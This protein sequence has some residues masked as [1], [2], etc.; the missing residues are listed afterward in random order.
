MSAPSTAVAE[1]HAVDQRLRSSP[2]LIAY[3]IG[4]IVLGVVGLM[5]RD[6]ATNWQRVGPQVPLRTFLACAAALCELVFGAALLWRRTARVAA[7]LLT[8]F[9]A[10]FVLLWVPPILAHPGVYDGYGN[11]FEELSLVI[12]GAVAVAWLAPIGSRWS[13]ALVPL[14]RLYGICV[15]SYALVHFFSLQGAAS[16]VPRWIPPGQ[17]FW[18]VTTAV[19]FLLAAASILT[20][21][22]SGLASRLLTAMIVGF[23]LLIWVPLLVKSP[24][25]HFIWAGNSI[26]IALCGAVWLISDA[27][28]NSAQ[29]AKVRSS[30]QS[31]ELRAQ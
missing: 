23:E 11:F 21:I 4:A 15:I 25:D 18:A 19:C 26:S 8:L 7:V 5:W 6:F 24:H 13:R 1:K 20:G 12:A 3:A 14:T 2:G 27:I 17:M 10:I 16:F 29:S 28:R 22:L 31:S 9:F 30:A